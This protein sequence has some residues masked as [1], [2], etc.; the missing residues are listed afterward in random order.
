MHG[1][2]MKSFTVTAIIVSVCF[3]LVLNKTHAGN[4]NIFQQLLDI[5]F[6]SALIK[7]QSHMKQFVKNL[8][9]MS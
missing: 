8:F 1:Q 4:T 6:S 9:H 2:K 5:Y 7:D 3:I